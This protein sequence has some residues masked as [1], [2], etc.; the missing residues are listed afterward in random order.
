[1][2]QTNIDSW[3][4]LLGAGAQFP[5]RIENGKVVTVAG[6]DMVEAQLRRVFSTRRGSWFFVREFGNG[7]HNFIGE[8]NDHV[9]RALI[10]IETR[11]CFSQVPMSELLNL[12]IYQTA[13]APGLLAVVCRYR[14]RRT[15][16]ESNFVFPFYRELPN[17]AAAAVNNPALEVMRVP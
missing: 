1:M 7:F 15:Q 9:L 6:I 16:I 12:E 10:E 3:L 11:D 17:M 8:P 14:V 2:A 5:L 4:R 13:L